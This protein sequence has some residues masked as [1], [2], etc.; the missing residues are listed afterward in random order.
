[1]ERAV[2]RFAIT[3]QHCVCASSLVYRASFVITPLIGRCLDNSLRKPVVSSN[4]FL[5]RLDFDLQSFQKRN[6]ASLRHPIP[7]CAVEGYSDLLK[8]YILPCRLQE[9]G[10]KSLF[11]TITQEI[12]I[13][14]PKLLHNFNINMATA[15]I[16]SPKSS[17]YIARN[18]RYQNNNQFLAAY[19]RKSVFWP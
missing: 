5:Y 19:G 7:N 15:V 1:M 8:V 16:L 18:S 17:L 6:R 12:C 4:L 11:L 2:L 10:L 14:D 3:V 13:V 9:N